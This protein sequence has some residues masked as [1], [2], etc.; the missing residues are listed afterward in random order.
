MAGKMCLL[1]N[2]ENQSRF[3]LVL[4][5]WEFGIGARCAVNFKQSLSLCSLLSFN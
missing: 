3:E 2:G 5:M 1:Q 4:F